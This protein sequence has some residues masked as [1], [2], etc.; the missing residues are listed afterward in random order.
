MHRLEFGLVQREKMHI[1]G[2]RVASL[3]G[4][5]WLGREA[6]GRGLRRLPEFVRGWFDLQQLDSREEPCIQVSL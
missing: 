2:V 1:P 5:L 3:E 4:G 6:N